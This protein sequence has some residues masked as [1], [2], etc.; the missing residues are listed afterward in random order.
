MTQPTPPSHVVGVDFGTLSGRAVVVRVS[1]G[2]ELALAV[3]EYT[4]G[5][6]ERPL[7]ASG[8]RAPAPRVRRAA[9]A[10]VGAPG[11]GGLRGRAAPRRP[12]GGPGVRRR[13]WP[14]P[15]D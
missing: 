4:H 3:H 9:T 1:D 10:A 11:P 2:A 13:P 15:G 12:G 6:I 8:E 5:V 14:D 7:P